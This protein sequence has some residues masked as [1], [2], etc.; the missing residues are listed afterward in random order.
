M[1][2]GE[3]S[4]SSLSS[5]SSKTDVENNVNVE[6]V[7]SRV[8]VIGICGASGC[9]KT[10]LAYN[11]EYTIG[12][13]ERSNVVHLDSC[14]STKNAP[15]T[16]INPRIKN[17]ERP[18]GIDYQKLRNKIEEAREI[19]KNSKRKGV[20]FI[21]VEGFLLFS[22]EETLML[23]DHKIFLKVNKETSY[24][25]RLNRKTR[26][27]INQFTQYFDIYVWPCYEEYNSHLWE[28]K[29]I[30]FIDG[31]QRAKQVY[32]EAINYLKSR[33][34]GDVNWDQKGDDRF[35]ITSEPTIQIKRLNKQRRRK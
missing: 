14:F 11:L 32:D 3:S 17:M 6:T 18:D 13:R 34:V 24:T 12:G 9:G 10:T 16:T 15:V 33:V 28:R 35:D 29:D 4:L 8:Q 7:K 31:S 30:G 26:S 22:D 25:R 20:Q 21:I 19:L 23:F 2:E 1:E 5:V 27:D